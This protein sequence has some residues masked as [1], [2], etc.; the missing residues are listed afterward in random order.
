MV[1]E[2]ALEMLWERADA[3]TVLRERFGL[4][5]AATAACHLTR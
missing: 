2:P 4:A 3:P 1:G 5:D